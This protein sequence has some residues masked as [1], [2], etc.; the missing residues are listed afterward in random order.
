MDDT[1]LGLGHRLG[2]LR[3]F[4]KQT[5]WKF[6]SEEMQEYCVQDVNVSTHLWHHFETNSRFYDLEL[7][8]ALI[9]ETRRTWIL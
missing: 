3:R 8:A 7:E 9:P 6:W 4:G 1:V 2:C 5:D